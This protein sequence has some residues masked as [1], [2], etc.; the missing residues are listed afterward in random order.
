MALSLSKARARSLK[1]D[2]LK[3]FFVVLVVK[4]LTTYKSSGSMST[5]FDDAFV[6]ST[7]FLLAAFFIYHVTVG[8]MV[9]AFEGFEEYEEFEHQ[10]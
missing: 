9:E 8:E 10:E 2:L 4:V 5:V 3:N 7:A 1:I 6:T